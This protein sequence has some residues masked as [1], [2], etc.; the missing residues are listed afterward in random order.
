MTEPKRDW[1]TILG[2]TILG[3]AVSLATTA[4]GAAWYFGNI[5]SRMGSAEDRLKILE[6]NAVSQ[7]DLAQRDQDRINQQQ[8]LDLRLNRMDDKLDRVLENQSGHRHGGSD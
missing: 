8:E 6:T 5:N 7:R 4:G 3:L 1:V 2:P